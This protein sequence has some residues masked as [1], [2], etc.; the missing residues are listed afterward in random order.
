MTSY[1]KNLLVSAAAASDPYCGRAMSSLRQERVWKA[2]FL[3][4]IA[5]QAGERILEHPCGAG[6][7]SLMLYRACPDAEIIG[8]D[9]NPEALR[10]ARVEARASRARVTFWR[11]HLNDFRA[12]SFDKIASHIT[13]HWIAPDEKRAVIGQAVNLLRPGGS[14]HLASWAMADW[15]Q[16]LVFCPCEAYNE[17][18]DGERH[19]LLQL[20]HEVG[21]IG[22]VETPSQS[23]NFGAVRFFQGVRL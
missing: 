4:R 3:Q 12:G 19:L 18:A 16:R 7:L 15:L 5:P 10:A 9:V 23:T 21:L 2:R 20:M 11:G 17:F 13:Y 14:L 8:L 6:L 22:V 1:V